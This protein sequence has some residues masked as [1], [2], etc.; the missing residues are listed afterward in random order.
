[1]TKEKFLLAYDCVV[2]EITQQLS[3]MNGLLV[4]FTT[5]KAQNLSFS[6]SVVVV[7]I[8]T[9]VI[10][11]GKFISTTAISHFLSFYLSRFRP[12]FSKF[13]DYSVYTVTHGE[14]LMQLIKAK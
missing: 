9:D 1:M 3:R 4:K 5:R 12:S 11:S 7:A 13:T 14:R 10:D 6:F 2:H 8:Y